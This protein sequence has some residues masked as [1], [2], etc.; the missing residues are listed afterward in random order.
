V[1]ATPSCPADDVLARFADDSLTLTERPALAR[2]LEHCPG[3]RQ[4]LASLTGTLQPRA[5]PG[6]GD[7]DTLKCLDP[8]PRPGLLGVL[9]GYEVVRVIG[10]GGMGVVLE[11][12]DP[13]LSRPV[14][15]KV[16][17]R[18]LALSTTAR[19][20][21]LREARAA[22][23]VSHENVVRIHAVEAEGR[24]PFLV[25]EYVA[26]MSLQE[27]LDKGGPIEMSE[28]ARLGEQI[29]EGLAAAHARGLVHRDIKP[30][31][32]LVQGSPSV[33][34]NPSPQ[35]PPRNGEGEKE[36]AALLSPSASGVF[37]AKL[38]DF[39]L[40]RADND[41]GLTRAGSVAGTPLYMA[42]EQ[43]RGGAVDTRTDLYALGAVL[44]RL[45]ADRPPLEA[46]NA[47]ALLRR[48]CDETPVPVEQINPATPLWL[49][50]L[51]ARLLE[52]DSAQRPQS[53][54]E[55][56]ELF[57]YHADHPDEDVRPPRRPWPIRRMVIAGVILLLAGF[58][59]SELTGT[60]HAV[61]HT[62]S[63]VRGDGMLTIDVA[64]DTEVTVAGAGIVS[65]D[66]GPRELPLPPGR[67]EVRAVHQGKLLHDE[68]VTLERRERLSV[69][70]HPPAAGPPSKPFV[71]HLRQ[72][73][74]TREYDTLA[75]TLDDARDG[76]AVVI[77]GN[78]P[79]VFAPVRIG[80]ALTIRAG[81]GFLPVF[82]MA[83][84]ANGELL[85]TDS[86]LVLEGLAFEGLAE[87][88]DQ[89]RYRMHLVS[90][91]APLLLANCRFTMNGP[92]NA[93]GGSSSL[94]DARNCDFHVLGWCPLAWHPPET[95][96]LH[97]NNNLFRPG[98]VL[99]IFN[100][101]AIRFLK[102]E[103]THNTWA[104]SG[105]P[106]EF[107]LE[108]L[109]PP[110]VEG[111]VQ[112]RAEGNVFDTSWNV[113]FL[114]QWQK[115]PVGGAEAQKLARQLLRWDLRRNLYSEGKPPMVFRHHFKVQEEAPD[116]SLDDWKE[117]W[118]QPQEGALQ[119]AIAFQGGDVKHRLAKAL[120]A[121]FWLTPGSAGART[122][123]QGKDLGADMDLVGPGIAYERWKKTP[124][125]EKWLLQ[126]ARSLAGR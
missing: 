9:G 103:L 63:A 17:A 6:A 13:H 110:K 8:P 84:K 33:E 107:R 29:A 85:Q 14:A 65:R 30:A 44:Y 16:L 49:A 61:A 69:T 124:E 95:A 115:E 105:S 58:L 120:P 59:V 108:S 7:D 21:F 116:I 50:G 125:Y 32:I 11:A 104:W 123:P 119:S 73:G 37:I 5:L 88:K 117:F 80:Y 41:P 54:V 19:K 92:C 52:K 1:S 40:A 89:D 78:G 42:P 87:G 118:G 83:P 98:S 47:F 106:I 101:G 77:H 126:T 70:A 24:S 4:K 94:I 66:T 64:E 57:R 39:G 100:A 96:R 51:I 45:C 122:T 46:D 25:M 71:L 2:H 48:I 91:K 112:V 82:R 22:A 114:N 121:D 18:Q 38:T 35:P 36:G 75:D 72:D 111:A 60:T 97:L 74:S 23:A 27:R 76:D 68:V 28:V 15:L 34:K 31:N 20:R 86:P 56:A 90:N 93:I 53:A 55:V 12:I 10:Q 81:P 79:F 113:F 99:A 102:L 43:A 26:G 3:C 67:Y 109:E 62:V